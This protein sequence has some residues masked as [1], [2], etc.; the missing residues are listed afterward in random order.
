MIV[1]YIKEKI[2]YKNAV[3]VSPDAGGA[4]RASNIA[5]KLN[6]DFAL[7]HKERA[8]EG[9]HGTD[10]FLVGDVA[11]RIAIIIDDVVDTAETICLASSI[12]K[13]KGATQII[14]IITHAILSGSAIDRIKESPLSRVIVSNTL[15]QQENMARC[16]KIEIM[17]ITTL[18]SEAIRRIHNGESVSILRH[19][20]PY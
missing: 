18:F 20:V 17:E 1:K 13:E 2:D 16:D 6:L 19:A 9:P 11:D 15:P 12:L 8:H 7:I 3:I 5:D 4:K 10:G 14:A